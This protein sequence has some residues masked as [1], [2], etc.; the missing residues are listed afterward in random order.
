MTATSRSSTDATA[1]ALRYRDLET[2]VDWLCATFDFE[3]HSMVR[4]KDGVLDFAELSFANDTLL[5]GSARKDEA[6]GVTA[7]SDELS[8]S[9]IQTCYL[10]VDDIDALRAKAAQANLDIVFDIKADKFIGRSVG[11]KD[12][13][14]NIW[15]F[16]CRT[17][18]TVRPRSQ[19]GV[20]A[21]PIASL[22][23][24]LL[25]PTIAFFGWLYVYA[26]GVVG[27]TTIPDN[28]PARPLRAGELK[29]ALVERHTA[30]AA[31]KLPPRLD[32]KPEGLDKQ[33]AAIGSAKNRL[34]MQMK[35]RRPTEQPAHER[36]TTIQREPAQRKQPTTGRRSNPKSGDQL[37]RKVDKSNTQL[38]MKPE[39]LPK[40]HAPQQVESKRALRNG[41]RAIFEQLAANE[42]TKLVVK[43]KTPRIESRQP[44]HSAAAAIVQRTPLPLAKESERKIALRSSIINQAAAIAVRTVD[45][46]GG[47]I[48]PR[49][50]PGDTNMVTGLVAQERPAEIPTVGDDLAPPSPTT[51]LDK[52]ANGPLLQS[53]LKVTAPPT[54]ARVQSRAPEKQEAPAPSSRRENSKAIENA[55]RLADKLRKRKAKS[56]LAEKQKA[57]VNN[58][59]PTI[60]KTIEPEDILRRAFIAKW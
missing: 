19:H 29:G 9:E 36:M 57:S 34:A 52:I 47:R 58:D 51:E 23:S 21:R 40:R 38:E 35:E 48:P 17:S 24:I 10:L 13:E 59:D 5:L 42:T 56:Q 15:Y 41:E 55:R 11:Y 7:Q 46:T 26:D 4:G 39:H 53:R 12:L 49:P 43:E 1:P 50:S 45:R 6:D 2:A 31:H 28:E 30:Q 27:R 3:V 16:G 37:E 44:S 25:I 33:K 22:A 8:S 32:D 60:S 14:G 54:A 20:D 18:A